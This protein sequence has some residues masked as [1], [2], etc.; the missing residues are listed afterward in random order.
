MWKYTALPCLIPLPRLIPL[1]IRNKRKFCEVTD[2]Q[3]S[4]PGS[5]TPGPSKGSAKKRVI[6]NQ[7]AAQPFFKKD[8]QQDHVQNLFAKLLYENYGTVPLR[9][10]DMF[11]PIFKVCTVVAATQVAIFTASRHVTTFGDPLHLTWSAIQL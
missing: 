7:R 6:S 2:E 10:V 9:L 4:Q 11:Q 8:K 1:Q 5:L 3:E